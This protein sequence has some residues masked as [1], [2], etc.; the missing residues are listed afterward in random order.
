MY[1]Y[2]ARTYSPTLGRFLQTDPIGYGDG[3]NWYNYVK[4]DPVNGV[5]PLGLIE[6]GPGSVAVAQPRTS[7]PEGD[8]VALYRYHCVRLPN[9]TDSGGGI[10]GP[11][12]ATGGDGN[13]SGGEQTSQSN[14]ACK[15][16]AENADK[17]K[18]S[19]PNYITGNQNW[20]NINILTGYRDLYQSSFESYSGA[21]G[22]WVQGAVALIGF[23][24]SA[25]G[26]CSAVRTGASVTGATFFSSYSLSELKDSSREAVEA[27]DAR[28]Q[29]LDSGC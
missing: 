29:Q 26:P 10:G 13:G 14:N 21:N 5:D 27:I 3:P 11:G 12:G 18:K 23:A 22:F 2:K 9:G 20:N 6:C 16:L 28:I 1:H 19:L 24:C 17:K 7:R 4:S 15:T 25:W 8:V